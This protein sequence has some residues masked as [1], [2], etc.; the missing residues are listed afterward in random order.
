MGAMLFGLLTETAAIRRNSGRWISMAF[1]VK[2][3]AG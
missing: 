2:R 1:Y 3:S